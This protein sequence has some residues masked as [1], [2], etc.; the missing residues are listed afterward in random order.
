[1]QH[2]DLRQGP[3]DRLFGL[4]CVSVYTAAGQGAD[5]EIVGIAKADAERLR[6]RLVRAAADDGV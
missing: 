2:V 3:L 6:E 5:A 4:A 1:V